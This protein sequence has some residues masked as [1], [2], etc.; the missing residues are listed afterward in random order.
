MKSINF[1]SVL[2][3][4]LICFVFTTNVAAQKTQKPKSTT[5]P[6]KEGVAEKAAPV[7]DCVAA[8]PEQE[9]ML[10]KACEDLRFAETK[11]VKIEKAT[12]ERNEKIKKIV[13]GDVTAVCKLYE[14]VKKSKKV[15]GEEKAMLTKFA[16]LYEM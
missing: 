2:S 4:A 13:S 16:A 7:A 6:T 9:K 11:G 12:Q 1:L 10:M 15:C 14:K 8:S 3:I 5:K